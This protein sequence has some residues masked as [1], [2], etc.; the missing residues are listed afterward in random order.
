MS[1]C[2]ILRG[3][4]AAKGVVKMRRSL[5]VET[6]NFYCFYGIFIFITFLPFHILAP[7][8]MLN[9]MIST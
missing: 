2:R 1:D 7:L 5:A 6:W 8:Y 9:T 4:R 3:R